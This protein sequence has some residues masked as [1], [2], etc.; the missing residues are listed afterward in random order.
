MSASDFFMSTVDYSAIELRVAE[1]MSKMRP[2]PH[3]RI[4]YPRAEP[5]SPPNV[6]KAMPKIE[7]GLLATVPASKG[8]K[9]YELTVDQLG[10]VYCS[11][12]AWKFRQGRECKHMLKFFD[13]N[14]NIARAHREAVGG[15][16]T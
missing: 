14:P 9:F 15:E 12:P 7:P 5:A 13:E 3:P 4:F 11:C 8:N 10:K 1:A 16:F 6:R 2:K